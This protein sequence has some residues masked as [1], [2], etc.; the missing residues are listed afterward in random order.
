LV[1]ARTRGTRA[2]DLPGARA[3]RT[4]DTL[5]AEPI[6]T[7]RVEPP[8]LPGTTLRTWQPGDRMRTRAG[9]RKL[10]DLFIDHRVPRTARATAR[11]LVRDDATIV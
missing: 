1:I 5:A 3:V 8:T 7:P 10:G 9:S 2:I 11:V 4:Y 6:V